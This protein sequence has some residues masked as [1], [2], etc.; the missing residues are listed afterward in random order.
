MT[1]SF[2]KLTILS[3]LSLGIATTLTTA[4]PPKAIAFSVCGL[5]PEAAAFKTKS[6]LITICLGEASYQLM[7]TYHDGTGYKRVPVQRE[8][9]RFRGTDGQQNY[10]IDR[11]Q[12][13]IGTD[14]KEPIRERVLTSR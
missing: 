12:F 2:L 6:Y 7:L 9:K 5:R 14:G 10:I 8:G 4:F 11:Q 1:P 13:V 3:L